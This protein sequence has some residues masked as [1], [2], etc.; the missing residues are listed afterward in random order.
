[1]VTAD[2]VARRVLDGDLARIQGLLARGER[3]DIAEARRIVSAARR[4]LVA[5]PAEP[6]D[7]G[8]E[9]LHLPMASDSL[10]WDCPLG[11]PVSAL[12]CV[13]RQ[14]QSELEIGRGPAVRRSS[15]AKRGRA[16]TRPSCVTARCEVGARVRLLLGDPTEAKAMAARAPRASDTSEA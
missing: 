5:R 15:P 8:Q 4:A 2:M 14:V 3:P 16:P 12:V 6:V 10:V 13:A 7:P 9:R 1:M 11:C